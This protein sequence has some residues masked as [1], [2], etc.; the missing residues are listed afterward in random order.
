MDTGKI[1]RFLIKK[2][3]YETNPSDMFFGT[4]EDLGYL[5]EPQKE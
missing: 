4:V 5:N 1:A 3:K 2:I